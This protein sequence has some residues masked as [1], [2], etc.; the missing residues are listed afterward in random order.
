MSDTRKPQTCAHEPARGQETPSLIERI[1]DICEGYFRDLEAD[2]YR[3][4]GCSG[5]EL[6]VRLVRELGLTEDPWMPRMGLAALPSH[7]HHAPT[8]I[9]RYVTPWE[10]A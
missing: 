7:L 3:P 8:P 2:A 1:A 5:D 6:A 9:I 10:P 4:E